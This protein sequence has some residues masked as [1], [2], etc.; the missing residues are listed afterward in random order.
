MPTP[1]PDE[2][3][4]LPPHL[5]PHHSLR[6]H[7]PASSYPWLTILTLLRGPQVMPP[8]PPSPPLT[9]PC[10]RLILSAAY[11]PYIGGV[12]SQHASNT[13]YNPYTCIVPA[14]HASNVAYHPYARSALLTCLQRPPHT[15]PILMLLQPPQDETMMPPPI[16]ALTTPY[17]SAPL[18]YHPYAPAAHSRYA[19]DATLN[20]P[21][22]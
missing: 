7:T 19:S 14:Q 12:P 2:I 4:T 17:A 22:A 8:T 5:R 18:P 9:P 1:P 6:F 3:R 15:G 11:H 16:S 20:P 10:T 13:A 21:Y